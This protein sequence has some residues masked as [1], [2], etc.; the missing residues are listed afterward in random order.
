[1][2]KSILKGK[3]FIGFYSTIWVLY[4]G[5]FS[6]FLYYYAGIPLRL[7]VPDALISSVLLSL[8]L[9][10]L[11]FVIRYSD[12][13]NVFNQRII[14]HSLAG[15]LFLVSVWLGITILLFS[16]LFASNTFYQEFLQQSYLIRAFFGVM[17]GAVV[18]LTLVSSNLLRATREAA[19]RESDLKNLV[20][21]TEL[22]ALKNQ[23]NPHFI[24]NSLNSISS[25]T[26]TAPEKAQTM[27]IRLSEF[28]R[29]A[30]GQDAT[31]LTTLREELENSRLYLQIE[32]VRFGEKLQYDFV[33]EEEHL[34]CR[35]PVM[36]LQ[37]LFEN[38][39]KHGLR[40]SLTSSRIVLTSS[41]SPQGIKLTI[42]NPMDVEFARFRGEGVGLENIRNR[43]RLIYGNGKLLQV[44]SL[45]ESFIAI[46][47]L[48]Q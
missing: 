32:Q 36:I 24:Y 5:F 19:S 33:V 3:G 37:P 12:G 27:V 34:D 29:Y 45:D 20:Q 18:F 23:L 42:T 38:A 28:L 1:M 6:L 21:Q 25:L 2:Q 17:M 40:E 10:S 13:E 9:L 4:A 16:S 47:E 43:L 8:M 30:L 15:L 22:Q 44:K 48:P 39:V 7:S 26:I 14:I 46:L 11:W 31:Q 41:K 35:L